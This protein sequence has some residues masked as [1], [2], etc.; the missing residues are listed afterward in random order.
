MCGHSSPTCKVTGPR[1]QGVPWQ[2]THQQ[3]MD[4]LLEESAPTAKGA[5]GA[6]RWPGPLPS[7]RGSTQVHIRAS[8]HSERPCRETGAQAARLRLC[9]GGVK[10]QREDDFWQNPTRAPAL[11]GRAHGGWGQHYVE[12]SPSAGSLRA[13][14]Q[15]LSGEP[16]SHPRTL[17][18]Q[19]Q[20]KPEPGEHALTVPSPG[21]RC[22]SHAPVRIPTH[23]HTHTHRLSV[24][25]RRLQGTENT[26]THTTRAQ[27]HTQ[28]I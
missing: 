7:R 11:Q 20:N 10:H 3:V 5:E 8:S 26:D 19:K 25:F 2:H 23:T 4:N 18:G 14:Q 13:W 24:S 21:N 22:R 1:G 28:L 15:T 17:Q 12:V 9:S 6:Q 16:P 27:T